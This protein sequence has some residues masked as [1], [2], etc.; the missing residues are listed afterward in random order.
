MLKRYG[1]TVEDRRT[2]LGKFVEVRG[3]SILLGIPTT[4][5]CAAFNPSAAMPMGF[6]VGLY[7]LFGFVGEGSVRMGFYITSIIGLVT[8]VWLIL[9]S[10]PYFAEIV[11]GGL[12]HY[13]ILWNGF[14]LYKRETA[15]KETTTKHDQQE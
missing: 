12:F 15:S 13:I 3:L 8:S 7:F 6:A 9:V 14:Y 5:I 4:F 11:A 1:G 10:R 2:G